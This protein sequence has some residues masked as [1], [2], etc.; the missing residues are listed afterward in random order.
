MNQQCTESPPSVMTECP[1]ILRPS[2]KY[3]S[4]NVKRSVS[5]KYTEYPPQC[6]Q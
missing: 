3:T 4:T 2:P 6:H 1:A 5:Q